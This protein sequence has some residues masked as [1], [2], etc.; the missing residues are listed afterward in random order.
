MNHDGVIDS[1][2][3]VYLGNGNPKFT[4]GFGPTIT[5]N[6][7]WKLN[8]FFS[9][10]TGFSIINSTEMTTT[11]EF[12][13]SNQ[14]TAV[15]RRWEKPGDVTDIPRALY[16]AGYNWL[17]SSRY[18]Q[19]GSFLRFSALT[20]RYNIDDLLAKKLGLKSAGVYV[21]AQNLYT[22]THYIGQDPEIAARAGDIYQQPIDYSTTP[23][24]KQYTLGITASF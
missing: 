24:S 6:R 14:S 15:L 13:Y 3:I 1:R 18:V 12:G 11:N 23:A 9:Y 20:L 2:D 16:N 17:G 5:W 4:G 7:N 21:T 8:A 10:R 22:F 19:D